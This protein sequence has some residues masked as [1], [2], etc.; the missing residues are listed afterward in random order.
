M[1]YFTP[2]FPFFLIVTL[3]VVID[4]IYG[5]ST[6][7][8]NK[9][10]TSNYFFGNFA[11]KTAVYIGSIAFAY[12]IDIFILGGKLPIIDLEN[13]LSKIISCIW[14]FNEIKSFNEKL[15]ENEKKDLVSYFN[16][17]FLFVKGLKKNLK[18]ITK[19]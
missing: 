8:K 1:L 14:V 12:L 4:S 17:F 10:F 16:Q 3:S 7:I 11:V 6:A 2:I 18:E 19:D 9:K 5:I 15:I 13:G